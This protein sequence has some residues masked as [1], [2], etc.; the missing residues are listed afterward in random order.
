MSSCVTTLTAD[1]A[2]TLPGALAGGAAYAV[3]IASQP[4]NQQC[5]LA[6]GSGT[7]AAANV[8]SVTVT[9]TTFR[10]TATIGTS[11]GTLT[12]PSGAAIIIPAGALPQASVISAPLLVYRLA[13]LLWALWL[14]AALVRWMRWAWDCFMDGGAWKRPWPKH[15]PAPRV[16]PRTSVPPAESTP[17]PEGTS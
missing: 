4:A 7:I 9:C 2:F 3:T 10:V 15:V 6:N 12:H 8:S 17:A 13:M 14:A 5:T 11:G 16:A 1:G